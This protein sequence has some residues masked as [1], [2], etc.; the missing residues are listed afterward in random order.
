MWP[1]R[2][3]MKRLVKSVVPCIVCFFQDAVLDCVVAWKNIHKTL[4]VLFCFFTGRSHLAYPHPLVQLRKKKAELALHRSRSTN[5]TVS[6]ASSS[7]CTTLERL[8]SSWDDASPRESSGKEGNSLL[9]GRKPA[10]SMA[11]GDTAENECWI[12][13]HV[14]RGHKGELS[15]R[16]LKTRASPLVSPAYHLCHSESL[17]RLVSNIIGPIQQPTVSALPTRH[18]APQWPPHSSGR[19]LARHDGRGDDFSI[20]TDE[21]SSTTS[22][23]C[24]PLRSVGVQSNTTSGSVDARS[25]SSFRAVP[26]VVYRRESSKQVQFDRSKGSRMPLQPIASITSHHVLS[27]QATRQ[28]VLI[29][30]L[31]ETLCFVSTKSTSSCS[32]P[33]FSEV[34]PTASGAELFYVWERPHVRLFIGTLAK[35]FN[36]ALFTSATKPYADSIL[37][38]LDPERLI[39]RRYYRHHCR[40]IPRSACGVSPGGRS[41]AESVGSSTKTAAQNVTSLTGQPERSCGTAANDVVAGR[42]GDTVPPSCVHEGARKSDGGEGVSGTVLV[43]DLRILK[44]PPELMIM[45]DNTEESVLA[46]RENALVVPPFFPPAVMGTGDNAASDDVLLSL[47]PLLEALLVVPDVRSVLRH[48]RVYWPNLN[49]K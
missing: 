36:L 9:M 24:H 47:I 7:S 31:D 38:R 17:H 49:E 16:V 40:Q 34:I 13:R 28:K 20:T 43:K 44:V 15:E 18:T 42:M 23:Q 19:S 2:G 25:N 37:R 26:S 30:D 46:N 6:H 3:H 45:V 5:P 4:Y 11:E 10:L 21:Y 48:G 22:S 27:Y 14:R 33:T 32:P 1:T 12:Q 41:L 35:L 29:M 8:G 39:R